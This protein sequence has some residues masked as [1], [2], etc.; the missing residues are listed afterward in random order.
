MI[1]QPR[2]FCGQNSGKGGYLKG[3]SKAPARRSQAVPFAVAEHG[4]GCW[5]SPHHA[6]VTIVDNELNSFFN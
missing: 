5:P 6:I 2:L 4:M 3:K 1:F